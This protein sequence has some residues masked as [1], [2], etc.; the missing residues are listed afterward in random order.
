MRIKSLMA[1][2]LLATTAAC[3]MVEAD[4]E[5]GR[6]AQGATGAVTAG[7]PLA[8]E[9]GLRVL[10]DGGNAMDAAITM[11]GILAVARPHMNGVGGDM[12]LIYYEAESGNTFVLN[13]SGRAGSAATLDALK[14]RGLEEMPGTGPLS[15]SVP[16]AVGGWAEA[17]NRFGTMEW[18]DV[19]AP[20]VELASNGLPVSE[21]LSL[22]IAAQ[23]EKLRRDPAAAEIFLPGDSPPEPGSTLPRP[24]LA[25]T[26]ERIQSNGPEEMYSGE[27]GRRIADYLADANVITL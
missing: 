3:A 16:G 8:A 23:V 22:D 1:P 2:A 5:A 21:R 20:A 24:A 12:F 10:Q 15:V 11:A 6:D 27:T 14:Q 25:A 7:H 17:L 19:L 26:L 9:A 4:P 18:A 13:A